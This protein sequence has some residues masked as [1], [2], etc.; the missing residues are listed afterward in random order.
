MDRADGNADELV[1]LARPRGGTWHTAVAIAFEVAEGLGY[2]HAQGC[3]HRD[4]KPPNVLR[5]GNRWL[6]GDLGVVRWNDLNP[7]FSS[8][9][10]LTNAAVRLGSW[11]YMA[12]EQLDDPHRAVPQSDIYSLGITLYELCTGTV[13]SP[14]RVAAR[15]IPRNTGREGIDDLIL[16]MTEFDAKDRPGIVD[17]CGY[18]A[19]YG[20]RPDTMVGR[21]EYFRHYP[22]SALRPPPPESPPPERPRSRG[23]AVRR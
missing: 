4:V 2:L 23:S 5:L 9:G 22:L 15:R 21:S 7:I 20:G 12:P 17:V 3:V 6:L 16:L 8:A 18:L 19:S 13:P 11:R 10:T 14:Q 1:E